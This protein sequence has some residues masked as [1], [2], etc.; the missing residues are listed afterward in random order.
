MECV[1]TEC[2]SCI[3]DLFKD[4]EE[5]TTC[6]DLEAGTFCTDLVT[7]TTG[8]CAVNDCT[9]PEIALESCEAENHPEPGS[10]DCPGLCE[11]G[12]G[13]AA[14]AKRLRGILVP[15]PQEA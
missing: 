13:P 9:A 8:S 15:A 10:D 7:C 1:G 5:S 11:E 12:G 6:A 14:D 3:V 2:V 4:L